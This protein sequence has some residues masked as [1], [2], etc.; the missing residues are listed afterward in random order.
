MIWFLE[1]WD[2]TI[3]VQGRNE[4]LDLM[5]RCIWFN[6]IWRMQLFHEK[7]EFD[8]KMYAF[9]PQLSFTANIVRC[10]KKVKQRRQ[11]YLYIVHITNTYRPYI[12]AT[13]RVIIDVSLRLKN[14]SYPNLIES[15]WLEPRSVDCCWAPQAMN[16]FLIIICNQDIIWKQKCKGSGARGAGATLNENVTAPLQKGF[17]WYLNGTF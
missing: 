9:K 8:I 17:S 5:L 12:R 4:R 2:D 14:Q 6:Q 13:I 16:H 11:L 15:I 7:I 3:L 10:L 1:Y